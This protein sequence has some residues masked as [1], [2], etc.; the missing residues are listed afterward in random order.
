LKRYVEKACAPALLSWHWKVQPGLLA[1]KSSRALEEARML[2]GG[3]SSC[4]KQATLN[5]DKGRV[6]MGTAQV[7]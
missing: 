7:I 5:Q 4:S 2:G 3:S 6:H 1:L